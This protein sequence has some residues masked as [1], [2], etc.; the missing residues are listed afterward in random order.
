MDEKNI[1]SLIEKFWNG[2]ASEQEI[3]LLYSF[4]ENSNELKTKFYEVF[5]QS[6]AGEVLIQQ[7]RGEEIL[8]IIDRKIREGKKK[9]VLSFHSGIYKKVMKYAAAIAIIFTSVIAVNLLKNGKA[10]EGNNVTAA[11]SMDTIFNKTNNIKLI[12]LPDKS[13]VSLYPKGTICFEHTFQKRNIS[14]T[15]K[16]SFK[17][18]HDEKNIFSVTTGEI[19]TTDVGTEFE[20]DAS[21]KEKIVIHLLTGKIKVGK[22]N[23]SKLAMPDQFLSDGETLKINANSGRFALVKPSSL[24]LKTEK[25]DDTKQLVFDKTSLEIVFKSIARKYNT[26]IIFNTADIAK[27]TFTGNI[28]QGDALLNILNTICYMNNLRCDPGPNGYTISRN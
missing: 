7:E 4:L 25:P 16:A 27:L 15:G 22:A 12:T 5:E 2:N 18:V 10:K 19:V 17:V 13:T 20:I 28:E 26:K 23:I 6:D 11:L 14:L 3:L 9:Y 24:L 1:D 8:K 21:K